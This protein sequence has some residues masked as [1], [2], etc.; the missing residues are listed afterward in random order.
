VIVSYIAVSSITF[1]VIFGAAVLG[2]VLRNVLPKD[3]LS[4]NSKDVVKLGM[5]LVATMTALVLGLLIA[6]AKESYDAQSTA[7]LEMSAKIISLDRTLARYGPESKES[8]ELLHS[9]VVHIVSRLWPQERSQMARL[10]PTR[11]LS[12]ALYDTIAELS[13]RDDRQR[14]LRSDALSLAAEIGQAR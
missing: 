7:L 4:E 5:G 13:P 1:C 2:M 9:E 11:G 8:R 12:G 14:L 3:H 10:A 6:S